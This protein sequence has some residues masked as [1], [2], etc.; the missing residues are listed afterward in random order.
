MPGGR[1]RAPRSPG[2]STAKGT[3]AP[4]T[5]FQ[6]VE[7]SSGSRCLL[8]SS[9]A[10]FPRRDLAVS[11]RGK[12]GGSASLS[13]GDTGRLT[14]LQSNVRLAQMVSISQL[15]LQSFDGKLYPLV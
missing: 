2:R 11:A 14:P 7:H 8:G 10:G 4:P 12:R 1:T 13:G 5:A 15:E 6:L 3:N 9:G